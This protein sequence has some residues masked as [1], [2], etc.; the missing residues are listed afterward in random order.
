MR[1]NQAKEWDGQWANKDN[2]EAFK[3]PQEYHSN[4]HLLSVVLDGVFGLLKDAAV[5]LR[6][7]ILQQM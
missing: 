1:G 5:P 4:Q 2:M 6:Y 3:N 7:T